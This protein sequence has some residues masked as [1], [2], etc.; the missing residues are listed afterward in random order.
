M[1]F[2]FFL[3]DRKYTQMQSKALILLVAMLLLANKQIFKKY[4]F[5][6]LTRSIVPISL[7]SIACWK[8]SS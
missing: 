6:S 8:T 1:R 7:H 5:Y 3:R 2:S 4:F